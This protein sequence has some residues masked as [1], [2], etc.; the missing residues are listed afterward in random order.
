[1]SPNPTRIT[2]AC[3][4]GA[5]NERIATFQTWHPVGCSRAHLLEPSIGMVGLVPSMNII[6]RVS[7]IKDEHRDIGQ[8]CEVHKIVYRIGNVA[9]VQKVNNVLHAKNHRH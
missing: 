8:E 4:S 1:M 5:V 3:G 6:P 2:D 9:A 7:I